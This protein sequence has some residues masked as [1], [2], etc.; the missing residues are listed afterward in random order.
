[1]LNLFQHLL[2]RLLAT[3]RALK[4]LKQV[5]DD[6]GRNK[7]GMTFCVFVFQIINF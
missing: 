4:G 2:L 7:S 6:W 5:Q 1:M 3:L